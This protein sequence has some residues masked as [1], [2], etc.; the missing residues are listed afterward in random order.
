MYNVYIGY[1]LLLVAW[2]YLLL[3]AS[4]TSFPE[5][6]ESGNDL[7]K[8]LTVTGPDPGAPGILGSRSVMT[9]LVGCCV[10]GKSICPGYVTFPR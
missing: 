2:T 3:N 9:E 6:S 4:I 8:F 7:V 5:N 1:L 10:I